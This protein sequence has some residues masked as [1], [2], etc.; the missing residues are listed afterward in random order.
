MAKGQKEA[1]VELVCVALGS[2]FMP[3]KTNALSLLTSAQL[4]HIKDS[5]YNG[6]MCGDISYGKALLHREVK[7]YASSVVM[8]HLKKAKELNGGQSA[9]PSS[10][11]KSTHIEASDTLQNLGIDVSILPDY[12]KQILR[13]G[14][15]ESLLSSSS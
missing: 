4:S 10:V 6:I 9:T 13:N 2:N 14:N 8:N 1:V 3:G 5:V 7:S 11:A 15:E 12:A